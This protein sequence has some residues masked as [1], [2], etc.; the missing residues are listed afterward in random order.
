[1]WV[2]LECGDSVVSGA[3][4]HRSINDKEIPVNIMDLGSPMRFNPNRKYRLEK[5]DKGSKDRIIV[6]AHKMQ[7]WRKLKPGHREALMRLGFTLPQNLPLTGEEPKLSSLRPTRE[8]PELPQPPMRVRIRWGRV[9][10][11]LM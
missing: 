4:G 2:E 11:E 3:F 1:M 5:G 8:E 6:T 9:F 10:R 7:G